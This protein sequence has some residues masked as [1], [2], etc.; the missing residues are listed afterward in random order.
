MRPRP[1]RT[2]IGSLD[3]QETATTIEVINPT[4]SQTDLFSWKMECK[5]AFS[6]KDKGGKIHN[7]I[8]RNHHKIYF[9]HVKDPQN[10]K[11]EQN[12][13]LRFEISFTN[14]DRN[15]SPI[16]SVLAECRVNGLSL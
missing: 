7:S 5:E 15:G 1:N 3:Q 12:K 10:E 2:L 6:L 13:Q 4:E 8:L 11:I 9:D 16:E 14:I